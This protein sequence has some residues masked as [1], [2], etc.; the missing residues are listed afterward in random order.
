MLAA[1]ALDHPGGKVM[2]VERVGT[3]LLTGGRANILV[4][5]AYSNHQIKKFGWLKS[6]TFIEYIREELA[7]FS[8]GMPCAM[9]KTFGFVNIANG[10]CY[11]ITDTVVCTEYNNDALAA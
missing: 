11:D 5:A 8:K 10:A 7:C 3:H 9:R 2:D 4:M 1:L 6:A